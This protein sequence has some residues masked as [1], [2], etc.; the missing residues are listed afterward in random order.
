M[1]PERLRERI[2]HTRGTLANPEAPFMIRGLALK[3]KLG[4]SSVR[5]ALRTLENRGLVTRAKAPGQHWIYE[6]SEDVGNPITV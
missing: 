2:M 1:G 6:V 3:Y 4:R 5:R